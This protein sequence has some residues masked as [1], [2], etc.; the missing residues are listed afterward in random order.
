M[1]LRSDNNLLQRLRRIEPHPFGSCLV[2]GH[3]IRSVQHR[4]PCF[5]LLPQPFYDGRFN[6]AE[7]A[8]IP[9]PDHFSRS[10]PQPGKIRRHTLPEPPG[11]V[12]ELPGDNSSNQCRNSSGVRSPGQLQM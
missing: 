2:D 7:I 6:A 9:H 5:G 4:C 10:I 3:I 1:I 11:N 8:V 12:V